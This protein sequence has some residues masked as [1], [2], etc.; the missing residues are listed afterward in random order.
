MEDQPGTKR[1]IATGLRHL[2]DQRDEDRC[3]SGSQTA[4]LVFDGNRHVV[5]VLNL[6][7][8]GAMIGFRGVLA[9]GADVQLQLLDHKAVTGQVRWVRDGRVGVAFSTPVDAAEDQR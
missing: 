8:S 7:Q 1:G 5:E 6:S 4:V 2:L 3:D 9:E